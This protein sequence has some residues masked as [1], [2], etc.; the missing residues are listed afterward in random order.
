MELGLL[1]SHSGLAYLIF[2]AALVNLVLALTP[3]KNSP[4]MAKVIG[5]LHQ[6]ILWGGRVNLLIGTT[7][8]IQYHFSRPFL[9][10]WWGWSA[11]LLWA[12]VEIMAKRLVQPDLKYMSD[13]GQ[14]SKKLLLGTGLQLVVVALIFGMMHAR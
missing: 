5:I 3:S 1:H 2:L 9:D 11:L 7:M 4:A 14:S 13:G 8:W 12:P 6:V 10:M